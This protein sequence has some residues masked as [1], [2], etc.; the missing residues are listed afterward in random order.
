MGIKYV[1][2]VPWGR[3]FDEYLEMFLLTPVDLD[4]KI[5]GVGDG[6]ASFNARMFQQGKTVISVD[7]IY[8]FSGHQNKAKNQR[9][10]FHG[11]C[12]N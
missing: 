5:I 9:N 7:P 12:S 1:D 11:D 8:Q 6:P 10:I 4:K 2:V 3:S